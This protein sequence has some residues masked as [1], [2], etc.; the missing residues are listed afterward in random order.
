MVSERKLLGGVMPHLQALRQGHPA[1]FDAGQSTATIT[2][3]GPVAQSVEQRIEKNPRN[4]KSQRLWQVQHGAKPVLHTLCYSAA[5]VKK[6]PQIE[7]I[8]H[9]GLAVGG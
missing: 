5:L 3:S 7:I 9:T 1:A 2:G 4:G 6:S 8:S